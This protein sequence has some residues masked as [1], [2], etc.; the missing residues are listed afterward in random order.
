M[1]CRNKSLPDHLFPFMAAKVSVWL[2]G[3]STLAEEN[4]WRCFIIFDKS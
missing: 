2:N 4:D 1:E 3:S